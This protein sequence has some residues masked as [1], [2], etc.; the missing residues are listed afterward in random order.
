MEDISVYGV[1]MPYSA[2]TVSYD[3]VPFRIQIPTRVFL[4]HAPTVNVN[5]K[6][7]FVYTKGLK[8]TYN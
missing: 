1:N 8:I 7:R 5:T 3:M 2:H 6:K 4:R